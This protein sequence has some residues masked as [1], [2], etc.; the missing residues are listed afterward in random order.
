MVVCDATANQCVESTT[1][2]AGNLGFDALY[3]ADG[4]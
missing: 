4:V 2:M 3:V 1:R